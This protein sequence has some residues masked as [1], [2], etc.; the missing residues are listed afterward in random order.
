MFAKSFY[1]FTFKAGLVESSG[2]AAIEYA[3][4]RRRGKALVEAF[5][6]GRTTDSAAHYR[7][8]ARYSI[9]HGVYLLGG[10]DDIAS[11]VG[12][13]SYFMGAG[14]DFTND[15]FKAFLSKAAF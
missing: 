13:S 12:G 10:F 11:T 15:D 4:N 8:T 1:D 9:F 5:D 3:F 7:A 14:L 6:F 2:G